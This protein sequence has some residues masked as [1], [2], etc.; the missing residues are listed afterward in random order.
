MPV[1]NDQ[2]LW[3]DGDK[4]Q[5]SW[6]EPVKVTLLSGGKEIST[7]EYLTYNNFPVVCDSVFIVYLSI[8]L[9]TIFLKLQP[10]AGK[11]TLNLCVPCVR[12]T[13]TAGA[14]I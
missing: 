14:G 7:Y 3:L 2:P 12:A 5:G 4:T 9:K 10:P 11:S 8:F 13:M 1:D 6:L